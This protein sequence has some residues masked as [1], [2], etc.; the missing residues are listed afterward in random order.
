MFYYDPD[1]GYIWITAEQLGGHVLLG[2]G[3]ILP[4]DPESIEEQRY[5]ANDKLRWREVD[6]LP[7]EWRDAF[8]PSYPENVRHK[9]AIVYDITVAPPQLKTWQIVF[10]IFVWLIFWILWN[11]NR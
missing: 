8:G 6:E 1:F 11:S 2:R 9:Q 7:D 4:H 10:V 5:T 3:P